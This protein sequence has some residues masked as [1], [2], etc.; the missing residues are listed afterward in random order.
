MGDQPSSA[1]KPR[2]HPTLALLRE[3]N[4]DPAKG[5]LSIGEAAALR[6]IDPTRPDARHLLPLARLLARAGLELMPGAPEWDRAAVIVN[7]MAL[8]RGHHARQPSTG[9]GLHA[10]GLSEERLMALL[11]AEFE[12]LRDLLPRIA[13]RAAASAQPMD[14]A[15]LARLAWH[16]GRDPARADRQRQRIAGDYTRAAARAAA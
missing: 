7:A 14:W 13:R 4:R 8:A 15:P 11:T 6:R 16:A 2:L 1:E 5:G 9:A 3:V 10:I 12:E